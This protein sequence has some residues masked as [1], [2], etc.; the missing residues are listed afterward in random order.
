MAGTP[1]RIQ[2][3]EPNSRKEYHDRY[4]VV[5]EKDVGDPILRIL[6]RMALI[7]PYVIDTRIQ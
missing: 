7:S 6:G 2:R 4:R 3:S 5:S 1:A